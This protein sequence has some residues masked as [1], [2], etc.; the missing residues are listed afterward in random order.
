MATASGAG[1]STGTCGTTVLVSALSRVV[2]A[3]RA[4]LCGH[5][6]G[7][8]KAC[9]ELSCEWLDEREGGWLI[10]VAG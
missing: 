7:Q 5:W 4:S 8:D 3:I 6:R 1:G 10:M 9:T 2:V